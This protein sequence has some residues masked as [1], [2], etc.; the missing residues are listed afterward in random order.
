[1]WRIAS[2]RPNHL[3]K[4]L[5]H[6]D[7]NCRRGELPDSTRS[8]TIDIHCGIRCDRNGS[9]K[10]R[11]FH[12]QIGETG[13]K[14]GHHFKSDC[15]QWSE[16]RAGCRRRHSDRKCR[17]SVISFHFQKW[18]RKGRDFEQ[19][20]IFQKWKRKAKG[21]DFEPNFISKNRRGKILKW[22]NE[23]ENDLWNALKSWKRPLVG[24]KWAPHRFFRLNFCALLYLHIWTCSTFWLI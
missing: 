18:K 8:G 5:V 1:M 6:F 4:W 15:L 16:R 21:R 12:C 19:N 10:Q 24:F 3:H 11:H 22:K 20:F 17:S 14:S 2:W 7:G 13:T 9:P 23:E